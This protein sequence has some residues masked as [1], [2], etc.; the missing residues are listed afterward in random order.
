MQ[1]KN[2]KVVAS[3]LNTVESKKQTY[4]VHFINGTMDIEILL[5]ELI[6]CRMG[7]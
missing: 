5:K 6:A 2:I 7:K 3:T 1:S 4:E